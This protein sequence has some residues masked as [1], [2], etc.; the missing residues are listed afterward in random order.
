M[1][2]V[3]QEWYLTFTPLTAGLYE[4]VKMKCEWTK[5]ASAHKLHQDYHFIKALNRNL[6]VF[7]YDGECTSDLFGQKPRGIKI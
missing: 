1:V 6:N 7:H 2:F 5:P 3:L 4:G